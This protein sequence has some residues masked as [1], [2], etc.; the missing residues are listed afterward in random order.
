MIEVSQLTKRYVGHLAVDNVSFQVE[1]GEIVGFLGPNGAG[2]STTIRMLTCFLTPSSGTASIGGYD[3]EKD[4]IKVRRQIGYMPENVPLYPDMRVNEY[5]RFRAALKG[6][7]SRSLTAGVGEAVET[8]S[9]NEVQN[10][11]IAT[12]SKGYRQRVGLADAL[13]T[14]PDLLILDEPT[15]GLDPQQI[16]QFRELIKDLGKRHTIFLSTH[17]LPEVEMTCGRVIII[18]RGKL[19][20]SD[21]PQNL[22]RRRLEGGDLVLELNGHS[23]KAMSAIKEIKGV[24]SVLEEK[25]EKG[26]TRFKITSKG[27][28]DLSERIFDLAV[29]RKWKIRE[30]ARHD[31]TLE[32][33]FVDLVKHDIA[34]KGAEG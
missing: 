4:S 33:A 6:M 34:G 21:T 13:V 31:A 25:T 17:I 2:K 9:L 11:M 8:C 19:K 29:E 26:W 7:S 27:T 30:L 28:P 1:K 32:D 15:N 23:G 22:V 18:N 20:A 14:K 12:L 16:R 5:L 3:I 10:K 24:S